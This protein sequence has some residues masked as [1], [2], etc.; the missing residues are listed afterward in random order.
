MTNEGMLRKTSW[1]IFNS[2]THGQVLSTDSFDKLSLV[3]CK[4]NHWHGY[5]PTIVAALSAILYR[6]QKLGA[7]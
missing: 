1:L 4:K 3:H 6:A 7:Q 5:S 2:V